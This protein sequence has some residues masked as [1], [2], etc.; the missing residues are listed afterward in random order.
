MS[1]ISRVVKK[2]NLW[3]IMDPTAPG[4]C[5]WLK[6]FSILQDGAKKISPNRVLGLYRIKTGQWD[7]IFVRKIK[8]SSNPRILSVGIKYCM[9]DPI[10]DVN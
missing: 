3:Q 1:D 10:C 7:S 6:Y 2:K 5:A 9:R 8:L 4:A